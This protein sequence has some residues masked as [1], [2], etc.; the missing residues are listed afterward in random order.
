MRGKASAASADS[1]ALAAAQVGRNA[2]LAGGG[3]AA[4]EIGT[5]QFGNPFRVDE[6]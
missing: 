2:V 5:D 1:A 3:S 6:D 4:E